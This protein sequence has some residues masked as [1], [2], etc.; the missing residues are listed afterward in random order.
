MRIGSIPGRL[1]KAEEKLNTGSYNFL[2]VL[3]NYKEDPDKAVE[4][5]KREN[6]NFVEGSG[7]YILVMNFSNSAPAPNGA[8]EQPESDNT[9]YSQ[10][11]TTEQDSAELDREIDRE[12]E[13]LKKHGFTKREINEVIETESVAET[14]P[15]GGADRNEDRPRR[16]SG[17]DLTRLLG[18]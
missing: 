2:M 13:A 14:T 8:P 3:V 18:G 10:E 6:P 9:E 16:A 17:S 7:T 1:K 15:G 11:D 12:M 4:R 5:A